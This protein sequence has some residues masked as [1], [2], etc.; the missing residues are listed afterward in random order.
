MYLQFILGHEYVL[1]KTNTC[2]LWILTM[3]G[4]VHVCMHTASRQLVLKFNFLFYYMDFPSHW[5]ILLSYEKSG[6]AREKPELSKHKDIGTKARTYIYLHCC[7]RRVIIRNHEKE[8]LWKVLRI[9]QS[10]SKIAISI[11][12]DRRTSR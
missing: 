8:F 1:W 4:F 11:Q 2:F 5:V 3:N 10:G 6:N 7:L 12:N 9:L